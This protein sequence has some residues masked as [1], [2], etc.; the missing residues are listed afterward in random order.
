MSDVVSAAGS[1]KRLRSKTSSA[2][3]RGFDGDGAVHD[4]PVDEDVM[5]I[6]QCD[7]KEDD[8]VV[9][10]LLE[11]DDDFC[12]DEDDEST[13]H[14]S[15]AL[16]S[17]LTT[18]AKLE[19]SSVI[20]DRLM[21]RPSRKGERIACSLCPFRCFASDFAAWRH[22]DTC[23]RESKC[24][25]CSGRKQRKVIVALYDHDSLAGRNP[26]DLL[27]RSA[28]I[29]RSSI[30]P[31]LSMNR[32]AIDRDIRLV[33]TAVGP[34]YANAV[35]LGDTMLVRRVGNLFYSRCFANLLFREFV[36]AKGRLAEALTR[37]HIHAC[38]NGSEI[39]NLFPQHGKGMWSIAQ[40]ILL[41]KPVC[42]LFEYFYSKLLAHNEFETLT[43][44]GTVKVC[45]AIMGQASGASIRKD[46][47]AAAMPEE[48]HLRRLV[49]VRGRSGSVLALRLVREEAVFDIAAQLRECFTPEQLAQ[50]KFVGVDQPSRKWHVDLKHVF[51]ALELLFQDVTHLALNCEKGFGGKRSE[52]SVALRKILTKFEAVDQ[53]MFAT[54][55]SN[56]PFTGQS[57]APLTEEEEEWRAIIRGK[58]SLPKEQAQRFLSSLGSH[59][60]FSSRTEFIRAVACLSIAFTAHLDSKGSNKNTVRSF[61]FNATSPVQCAWYFNNHIHRHRVNPAGL[62]LLASGTTG[63]EALH[64]EL[65]QAFRQTI[66]LHQ[67]TMAT[68][69]R[70]F[71]FGKL[72]SFTVARFRP[73]SRQMRPAQ[74]LGRAL[75]SDI[76]E[77]EAWAQCCEC[78]TPGK[79][80]QKATTYLQRWRRLDV[81]RMKRWLGKKPKISKRRAR[82]M[83]RTVFTLK[84]RAVRGSV[85]S[86][87]LVRDDGLTGK[88]GSSSTEPVP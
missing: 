21:R 11:S 71:L 32:T 55:L 50:V 6:I 38:S 26:T 72:L 78:R 53:K 52:G 81:T 51:P 73:T 45:L 12:E 74:I 13:V 3:A 84:R 83:K 87:M 59:Q 15:D 24:F 1:R 33:L 69:M 34:V 30:V 60:P 88:P 19:T 29:L 22:L 8:G 48:E 39:S 37:V 65:K 16:L 47:D 20:A 23:H 77:K 9:M 61:L 18:E 68:K 14:V 56:D 36:M 62:P 2:K 28:T 67:S 63:N 85:K 10:P 40:D 46:A 54:T 25:V 7:H 49:T 41:L 35:A 64:N 86:K 76:F 80:L 57:A 70:V 82:P 79:A 44:D 58:E 5:P 43:M 4:K 27:R 42:E 31:P 66:R 75:A 17:C